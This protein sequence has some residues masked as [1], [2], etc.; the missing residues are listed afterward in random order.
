MSSRIDVLFQL[1]TEIQRANPSYTRTETLAELKRQWKSLSSTKRELYTSLSKVAW[2]FD[3][4]RTDTRVPSWQ[5]AAQ[6]ALHGTEAEKARLISLS[7]SSYR[8]IYHDEKRAKGSRKRRLHTS[9]VLDSG[10]VKKKMAQD[11]A[12]QSSILPS[13]SQEL[14]EF[15]GDRRIRRINERIKSRKAELLSFANADNSNSLKRA[16]ESPLPP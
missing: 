2:L 15:L 8:Q 11:L 16:E 3:A 1:E 5:P 12:A 4:K 14:S 10:E 9:H 13:D 7:N 6:Y